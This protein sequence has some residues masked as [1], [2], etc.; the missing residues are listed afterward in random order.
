MIVV[1]TNSTQLDYVTEGTI[2]PETPFVWVHGI[3]NP[4]ILNISQI[5]QSRFERITKNITKLYQNNLS[6]YTMVYL[7]KHWQEL[8]S[9]YNRIKTTIFGEK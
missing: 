7:T 2:R 6:Q 5:K 1:S 4:E 3:V 8:K 9:H